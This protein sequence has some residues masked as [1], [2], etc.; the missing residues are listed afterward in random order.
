[1]NA[2]LSAGALLE[3]ETLFASD[4][5]A[6]IE[7]MLDDVTESTEA[8]VADRILPSLRPALCTAFLTGDD[9]AWL[10]VYRQIASVVAVCGPRSTPAIQRLRAFIAENG[11]LEEPSSA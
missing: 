11:D 6:A 2:G 9:G 8:D 3:V 7:R 4:A 5:A 10:A 1:M